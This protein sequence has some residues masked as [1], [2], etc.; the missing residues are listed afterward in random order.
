MTDT[1][2]TVASPESNGAIT[3]QDQ[4][5]AQ[6]MAADNLSM[7]A[8]LDELRQERD[9]VVAERDNLQIRAAQDA[10]LIN[11]Q[12]TRSARAAGRAETAEYALN[13]FKESVIEVAT[14][15]AEENGWCDTVEKALA[16]L[17]LKMPSKKYTGTLILTI[18]FEAEATSRRTEI[19]EDMVR[20][21]LLQN[22][23]DR[24]VRRGFGLSDHQDVS[25]SDIDYEVSDIELSED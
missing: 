25:I 11:E 6:T 14:K 19:D 4:F 12:R 23:L 3:L 18:S 22:D 8:Q 13:Q 2:Q 21:N 10:T 9:A 5:N 16:E 20:G 24:A 15:Y 1:E 17:G 7:R